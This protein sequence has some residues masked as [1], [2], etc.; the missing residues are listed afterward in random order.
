M[1]N[2]IYV[3]LECLSRRAVKEK[4]VLN[5]MLPLYNKGRL[6]CNTIFLQIRKRTMNSG[7]FQGRDWSPDMGRG[8][9]LLILYNFLCDL[10]F[11]IIMCTHYFLQ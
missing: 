1:K 7:Y 5:S 4:S 6:V 3:G 9:L 8:L 10:I 11:F 2:S